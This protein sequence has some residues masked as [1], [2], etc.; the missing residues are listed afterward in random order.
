MN[1]F[2]LVGWPAGLRPTRDGRTQLLTLGIFPPE[3]EPL[4][5]FPTVVWEHDRPIPGLEGGLDRAIPLRR[6]P[7]LKVRGWLRGGDYVEPPV[8]GIRRLLLRAGCPRRTVDDLAGALPRST[9]KPAVSPRVDL[10]VDAVEFLPAAG[11][12]GTGYVNQITVSGR[13]IQASPN[14]EIW[15]ITLETSTAGSI[16]GTWQGELPFDPRQR[17]PLAMQGRVHTT[18]YEPPLVNELRAYLGRCGR[19]DLI[20][21]VLQVLEPDRMERPLKVRVTRQGLRFH[22]IDLREREADVV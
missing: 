9:S 18:N 17:P 11:P 6:R 8:R 5:M 1:A 12:N 19:A 3:R 4:G 15:R 22:T 20:P 7:M 10:V 16:W 2:H 21:A 13:A 14:G